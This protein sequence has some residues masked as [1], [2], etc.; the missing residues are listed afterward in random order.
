MEF[1]FIFYLNEEHYANS[2]SLMKRVNDPHTSH[3]V[4]RSIT[5]YLLEKH[6]FLY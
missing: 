3:V 4:Y 6:Y 5:T 2:P 1:V